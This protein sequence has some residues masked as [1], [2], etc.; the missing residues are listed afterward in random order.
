MENQKIAGRNM[1][2]RKVMCTFEGRVRKEKNKGNVFKA[3]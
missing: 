2:R 3:I 1:K